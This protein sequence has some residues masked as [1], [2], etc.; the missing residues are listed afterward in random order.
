MPGEKN[1]DGKKITDA[2]KKLDN[3]FEQERLHGPQSEIRN[4][5]FGAGVEAV[6]DSYNKLQQMAHLL[7]SVETIDSQ[8]GSPDNQSQPSNAK[9]N[10]TDKQQDSKKKE[11]EAA[12][13]RRQN[14]EEKKEKKVK[15]RAPLGRSEKKGFFA[16]IKEV[17]KKGLDLIKR[18]AV[19]IGGVLSDV[20]I[21]VLGGKDAYNDMMTR[22]EE[23]GYYAATQ[24]FVGAKVVCQ[25]NGQNF[26]GTI[27]SLSEDEQGRVFTVELCNG[28]TMK[29]PENNL[30][31]VETFELL[32]NRR[33]PEFRQTYIDAD[34][35]KRYQK[36]AQAQETPVINETEIENVKAFL[37]QTVTE[38]QQHLDKINEL[39]KEAQE[40]KDPETL[41]KNQREIQSELDGIHQSLNDVVKEI[42]QNPTVAQSRD[43]EVLKQLRDLEAIK[44][45]AELEAAKIETLMEEEIQSTSEQANEGVEFEDADTVSNEGSIDEE[46]ISEEIP[47]K[48]FAEYRD[49]MGRGEYIKYDDGQ[50]L[51]DVQIIDFKDNDAIVNMDGIEKYVPIDTLYGIKDGE[52]IRMEQSEPIVENNSIVDSARENSQS[53]DISSASTKETEKEVEK[54]FENLSN[55]EVA[56]M[57]FTAQSEKS[58]VEHTSPASEP[59]S[60]TLAESVEINAA[61]S[62]TPTKEFC[63]PDKGINLQKNDHVLYS[64]KG[65]Y[66]EATITAINKKGVEIQTNDGRQVTIKNADKATSLFGYEEIKNNKVM[67]QCVSDIHNTKVSDDFRKCY[68]KC[69][70][71]QVEQPTPKVFSTEPVVSEKFNK[72]SADSVDKI[73]HSALEQQASQTVPDEKQSAL[74]EKLQAKLAEQEKSQSNIVHPEHNQPQIESQ[75]QSSVKPLDF[76]KVS[77]IKSTKDWQTPEEKAAEATEKQ[78]SLPKNGH[79]A[80]QLN[81]NIDNVEAIHA[82]YIP[83]EPTMVEFE[84]DFHHTADQLNFNINNVED[85]ELI[86]DWLTEEERNELDELE[87]SF[88]ID[89]VSEV[90]SLEEQT[91][92]AIAEANS[93]N[94]QDD[95]SKDKDDISLDDM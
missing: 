1:I 89:N 53:S 39:V 16:R 76:S 30:T 94:G 42:R 77:E 21:R 51:K 33:P 38:T 91:K 17:F 13:R 8:Y 90:I 22:R 9:D 58:T 78:V 36:E 49:S 45:N 81:F 7:S 92:Q 70:A 10:D 14:R 62:Q 84:S 66:Q 68:E 63:I 73:I 69:S 32:N 19:G 74:W 82:D 87:D 48:Q 61:Q 56:D 85:V 26:E 93:Q 43:T 59:A 46:N 64:F 5:Y 12:S 37:D 40:S 55:E 54:P 60:D 18:G 65:K 3:E 34:T 79:S 83:E 25:E 41:S 52:P 57:I 24:K 80:N 27:K 20:G 23:E 86:Q 71:P 29:I 6:T 31:T 88:D 72:E 95:K 75:T 28:H 4:T 44:K 47:E 2:K 11:N 67:S 35:F 15:T 50:T